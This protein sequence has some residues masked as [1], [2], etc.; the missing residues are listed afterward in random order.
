MLPKFEREKE[1]GGGGLKVRVCV[2]VAV[3]V[4]VRGLVAVIVGMAPPC[5]RGVSCALLY[6]KVTGAGL[7]GGVFR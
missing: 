3:G 5:R 4:W 2:G 7:G 6:F 1:S